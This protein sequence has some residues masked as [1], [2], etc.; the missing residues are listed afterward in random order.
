M[1]FTLSR[2]GERRFDLEGGEGSTLVMINYIALT[3]PNLCPSIKLYK[4]DLCIDAVFSDNVQFALFDSRLLIGKIR[5]FDCDHLFLS[6]QTLLFKK[7]ATRM[8]V[9]NSSLRICNPLI[10]QMK[11]RRSQQKEMRK[12]RDA[13]SSFSS[14]LHQSRSNSQPNAA[15]HNNFP[16]HST[17]EADNSSPVK[18]SRASKDV[19]FGSVSKE[20]SSKGQSL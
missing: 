2:F 11:S 20:I 19:I 15:T 18:L 9:E 14:S 17:I 6:P 3:F 5:N 7:T 13:S 10:H 16:I 1:V 8:E 4:I 12:S